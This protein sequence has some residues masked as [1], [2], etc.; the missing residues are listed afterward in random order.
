MAIEQLQFAPV[1]TPKT[2]QEL[3]RILRD[4][5]RQELAEVVSDLIPVVRGVVENLF[6]PVSRARTE[7]DFREIFEANSREF[8]PYRLYINMALL[9]ALDGPRFFEFYTRALLQLSENVF[10]SA[11]QKGIPAERVETVVDGYYATFTALLKSMMSLEKT[12][13][14]NKLEAVNLAAWI[15]SST[16]LD[17]GLTSL[18]LILE[19]AVSTPPGPILEL[20]VVMAEDSL[21]NFAAQCGMLTEAAFSERP[22]IKSVERPQ[23]RA[24]E[25]EWLNGKEKMGTLREFAGKWIVVEQDKLIANDSSYER[26]RD[27]ARTAGIARPFLIFVPETIEPAFMGL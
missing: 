19:D 4:K 13:N 18:F 21:N 14:P 2:L 7:N 25:M 26:A 22:S 3:T 10:R 17:F 12:H 9:Q 11:T 1:I 23:F 15:R 8:E 6:E 5:D 20:L 16:H 24:L 27:K